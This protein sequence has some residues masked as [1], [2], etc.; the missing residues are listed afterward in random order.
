MCQG[1]TSSDETRTFNIL[2]QWGINTRLISSTFIPFHRTKIKSVV[3]LGLGGHKGMR[4]P[5][6]TFY[7]VGHKLMSV[8]EFKK[9]CAKVPKK[10][11]L[12]P[13]LGSISKVNEMES[14]P[15]SIMLSQSFCLLL[16]VS[17]L[18]P[19]IKH[20]APRGLIIH[21]LT[22]IPHQK[23]CDFLPLFTAPTKALVL[24]KAWPF[25]QSPWVSDVGG[26]IVARCRWE[27]S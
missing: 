21:G 3:L 15:V 10:S 20:A 23:V 6:R 9:S 8:K 1:N 19:V 16:C 27:E 18:V 11:N 4:T 12:K 24:F 22:R 14:R 26:I 5:S 7:I 25:W 2:L 17:G 13:Y